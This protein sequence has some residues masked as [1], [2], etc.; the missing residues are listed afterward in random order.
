MGDPGWTVGTLAVHL[1]SQIDEINAQAD[2]RFRAQ[3]RLT[4]VRL[5]AAAIAVDTALYSV[6]KA[7]VKAEVANEKRF[8]SVNEFRG[9]LADAQSHFVTRVE[10]ESW[11]QRL[12]SLEKRL[13]VRDGRGLGLT[14]GWGYL[15]TAIGIA[16]G[17][18]AL[19]F[20]IT[21]R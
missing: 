3:E 11:G 4:E 17:I 19:I 13:N 9:A 16:A 10:H 21:G 5:A 7:T 8:D 1:Q 6:E 20:A 15:A 2:G 18:S 14:S 12:D